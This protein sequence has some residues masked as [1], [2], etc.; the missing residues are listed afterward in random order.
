MLRTFSK[1]HG[2]AGVR[3]GYGIGPAELM[4]YFAAHANDVLVSPLWPRQP[5]WPR[6]KTKPTRAKAVE[7]NAEEAERVRRDLPKL[8]YCARSDLGELSVLRI[9]R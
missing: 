8:G 4:S 9:G 1:A 6:L 7:N 5:R 3:V 2:L